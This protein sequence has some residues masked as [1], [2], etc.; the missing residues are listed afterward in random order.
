[1]CMIHKKH[2]IFYRSSGFL[3]EVEHG[4]VATVLDVVDQ[5]HKLLSCFWAFAGTR[6]HFFVNIA[7][8]VK[9]GYVHVS[10]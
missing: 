1:M 7:D 3:P 8:A 10:Q 6:C 5:L 4:A 2:D 9:I